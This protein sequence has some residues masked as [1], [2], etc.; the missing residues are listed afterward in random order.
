MAAV[1]A[2]RPFRESEPQWK[3]VGARERRRARKYQCTR[4]LDAELSLV[5]FSLTIP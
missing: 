1:Q 3:S 2:I 5:R 4:Q